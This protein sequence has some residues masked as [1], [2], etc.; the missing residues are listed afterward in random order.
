MATALGYRFL[1]KKGKEIVPIGKNLLEIEKIDSSNIIQGLKNVKVKVACDVTNL[2]YGTDGAAYVYA[3]QKGASEDEVELL[4]KGL[5]K[6]AN[7]IHDNFNIDLQKIKGTG[8][9]GGMGAGTLVFL[10][11][12]LLSG[13]DLVKE[14]IDF[15]VKIKEADWI[16]TGEG[17]FDSQTLSGKTIHGVITSAKNHDIPVATLCGSITLSESTLKELGIS[18]SD[19]ILKDAKNIEDALIN[20]KIYLT[21][22]ATKFAVGIQSSYV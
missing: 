19:A 16:V 5:E 17:K 1:D 8:A 2:L 3:L 22:M 12:D 6:L 9:A 18:Y 15:D 7:L 20:S 21:R 10:N 14:L 4:D 13:I 11:A